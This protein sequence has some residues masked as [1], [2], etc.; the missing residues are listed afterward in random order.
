VKNVGAIV[1]VVSFHNNPHVKT[2][3][4]KGLWGFKERARK[5]WNLL[6]KGTRVLFYGDGGIRLAGYVED[7]YESREPVMEWVKNPVGYPLR[8][9]FSL[10]NRDV[11]NVNPIRRNELLSKYGIGLAKKGFRGFGLVIFGSGGTYPLKVFD[12]IWSEFL[13][14]NGYGDGEREKS[15]EGVGEIRGLLERYVKDALEKVRKYP[16]KPWTEENTKAVLVEPLLKVLGWD[17]HNLDEVERGYQVT[18]GTKK[19]EVDYALKVNG[20]PKAFLEVKALGKDLEPYIE[21]ALSYAKVG[22]VEWVILTNGRE[23]RVY[24][25]TQKFQ[26]IGLTLDEYV[27]RYDELLLLSKERM[28]EGVLRRL[29]DERYHREAVLRWF[30]ESTGT[31]VSEIVRSNPRLK[32]EL[33]EKIVRE[34]LEKMG[35]A[36][37]EGLG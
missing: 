14:R 31:L 4:E 6:E 22:D 8:V 2:I 30:R 1:N 13:R 19:V 15:K 23:L 26:I 33:V 11:D 35:F 16:E 21:Q 3:F 37:G 18:V 29:V 17:V 25:A 10:I 9:T 28:K 27:K 24:D 5:R 20:K 32:A 36:G 12:D 7:K 34:M